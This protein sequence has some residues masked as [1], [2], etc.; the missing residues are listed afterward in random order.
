MRTVLFILASA[1][2]LAATDYVV[3]LADLDLGGATP[4]ETRDWWE[5]NTVFACAAGAEV[6]L[7][8]DRNNWR[9]AIR[10]E[11]N[12]KPDLLLVLPSGWRQTQ[13]VKARL[14]A[15]TAPAKAG[16]FDA[17]RQA[18]YRR[19]AQAGI[20]GAA[21]FRTL[22]GDQPQAAEDRRRNRRDDL[23][24]SIDLF[25]GGQALA[26]NLQLDRPL[27]STNSG[28]SVAIAS[29]GGINAPDLD[30]SLFGPLPDAKTPPPDALAALI[31]ADQ[32]AVF[33]PSF[34][35]MTE[36]LDR[37]DALG[38]TVLNALRAEDG[39]VRE[40][41]QRQLC[42]GLSDLARQF[43][44]T[45]V[46]SVAMTG[47]DLGLRLGSDVAV[48]FKPRN[49]KALALLKAFIATQQRNAGATAP[50]VRNLSGVAVT[51]MAT[52]DRSRS[53][54]L[55]AIGGAV[56]VANSE[57]QLTRLIATAAG[58]MPAL[59]ASDDYRHFR[60][61]WGQA[62]DEWAFAV[63]TDACIRRWCSPAARIAD[64]RRVRAAAILATLQARKATGQPLD[65]TAAQLAT[66]M[67]VDLG[68]MTDDGAGP[69]SSIYGVTGFLTPVNELP[70]T[71]VSDSEADAYKS[72][73]DRYQSGFRA[74]FDPVCLRLTRR[75]H[76]MG[77]SLAVLPLIAGSEYAE[78]IRFTGDARIGPAA[79]DPHAGSLGQVAWAFDRQALDRNG[80]M[81]RSVLPTVQD[82][83]SWMGQSLGLFA[84]ADP[85]WQ[86]LAAAS[87]DLN[88][89]MER[90]W[91]RLPIGAV[92]EVGDPF[93]LA[94]VLTALRGMSEQ[95]A[96]GMLAWSNGTHRDIPFVIVRPS[97]AQAGM[98]RELAQA[99][100]CYAALPEGLWLTL[101]EDVLKRV[102][103][104]VADRRAAPAE[105]SV[106]PAWLGSTA[107]VRL[108]GDGL[109]LMAGMA[110]R[111]ASGNAQ[112]RASFANLP[113][114]NEW[115]RRFPSENPVAVHERLFGIR[116]ICPGGQGY[117]YDAAA[118]TMA[119]VAYGHPAAPLDGPA[120]PAPLARLAQVAAGV[121]LQRLPTANDRLHTVAAG[122]T[123]DTVAQA[124][125]VD[126][127][128]IAALNRLASP[129]ALTPGMVLR[130]PQKDGARAFGLEAR[131][132]L[133]EAAP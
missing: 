130:I 118:G 51:V 27:R 22:A 123:L 39:L 87:K 23:E 56:V 111:S 9:V 65:D 121:T 40:R 112:Q 53:S 98:M 101:R 33:F 109:S 76:G 10:V 132:T 42:L 122:D 16:E 92:I 91:F 77:V 20:P 82:P 63:L 25:T 71:Q 129:V 94:L 78:M 1:S 67:G 88:R 38:G 36:V 74:W 28:G 62:D 131:L 5:S 103:D 48:L 32:H 104:R 55:A 119:S 57:A 59:A 124:M 108:T 126:P 30:W 117:R 100:L 35:A 85:F 26:E 8:S 69:R 49:E 83:L 43:G 15:Q 84:D 99:S 95:A 29:L 45:L 12:D 11:G 18:H 133:D 73:R 31:P 19:L 47:G 81:L 128:A 7:D 4:P 127:D 110:D 115:R 105:K 50:V 41:Y 17:I 46:A 93:K 3:P 89:F 97:H 114:L 80:G 106:H 58:T 60:A 86:E 14:P 2:L 125:E 120:L 21:V 90:S 66:A 68:V 113:I 44:P 79:A 72:W 102:L 37:A 96:P 34:T 75:E 107:A 61:R 54:Y 64:S 70:I 6:H 52:A 116:L 13:V 24:S